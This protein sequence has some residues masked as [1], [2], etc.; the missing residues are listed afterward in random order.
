MPTTVEWSGTGWITTEPAPDPYMTPDL[1]APQNFCPGSDHD[2]VANRRVALASLFAS[3]AQS[4]T[5]VQQD[6]QNT[7]SS[8]ILAINGLNLLFNR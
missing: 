3:T 2:M 5:L 6:L 4:Y 8:G 1:D 7:S